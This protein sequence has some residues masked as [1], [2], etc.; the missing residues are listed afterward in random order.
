M[1]RVLRAIGVAILITATLNA[2]AGICLCH[3][4]PDALESVPGSHNCC[5][6]PESTGPLAIGGVLTCCHIEAAQR[7]M[8]AVDAIQ[9]P[10]PAADAVSTVPAPGERV[11]AVSGTTAI[12]PSP[13]VRVLRL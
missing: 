11:V 2:T 7:D 10:P 12:A 8:T 9:L 4:G 13:P 1:T 5:R 3:R 6:G